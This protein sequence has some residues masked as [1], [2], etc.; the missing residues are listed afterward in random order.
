MHAN[1]G[2]TNLIFMRVW[3]DFEVQKRIQNAKNRIIL[4]DFAKLRGSLSGLA[5]GVAEISAKPDARPFFWIF[6]GFQKA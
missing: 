1:G 5:W 6:V 2:P 4:M 3:L